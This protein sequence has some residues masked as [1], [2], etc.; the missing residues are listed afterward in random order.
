MATAKNK[1]QA[2]KTA[3]ANLKAKLTAPKGGKRK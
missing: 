3:P 2:K 1:G